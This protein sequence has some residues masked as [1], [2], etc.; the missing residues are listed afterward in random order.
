MTSSLSCLGSTKSTTNISF[1][2]FTNKSFWYH[3][4]KSTF[5]SD[6][7]SIF[8]ISSYRLDTNWSTHCT[9]LYL[10]FTRSITKISKCTEI[11][12]VLG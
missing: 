11:E 6:T 12:S 7:N 10:N 9:S 8:E 4:E 1:S 3:S 2:W 5:N